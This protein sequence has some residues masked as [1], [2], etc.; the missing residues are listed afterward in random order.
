MRRAEQPARKFGQLTLR[1][2][3]RA[4]QA[5]VAR[6]LRYL[7]MYTPAKQEM[8]QLGVLQPRE[9]DPDEDGLTDDVDALLMG[10]S[11]RT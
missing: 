3:R 11:V 7:A 1:C 6:C 10:G 2:A 5:E 4:T 9:T 8:L